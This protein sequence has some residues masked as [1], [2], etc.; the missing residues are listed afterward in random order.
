[1]LFNLFNE[2]KHWIINLTNVN[3]LSLSNSTKWMATALIKGSLGSSYCINTL[4]DDGEGRDTPGQ[5]RESGLEIRTL[6][7]DK[8]RCRAVAESGIAVANGEMQNILSSQKGLNG[9]CFSSNSV[10]NL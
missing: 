5:G 2:I 1:M 6:K 3:V 7:S 9:H 8:C 4:L 10:H